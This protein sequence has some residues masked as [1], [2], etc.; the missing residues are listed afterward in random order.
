VVIPFPLAPP[1]L[2]FFFLFSFLVDGFIIF[3]ASL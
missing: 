3:T 1:F 2:F